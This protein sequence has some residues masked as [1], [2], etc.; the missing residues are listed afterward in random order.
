[1]RHLESYLGKDEKEWD[2]GFALEKDKLQKR[3]LVDL[4]RKYASKLLLN[5]I[6]EAKTFVL[7]DMKSYLDLHSDEK[8]IFQKTAQ[9]R[10]GERLKVTSFLRQIDEILYNEESITGTF[11]RLIDQLI[12]KS[13][14]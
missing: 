7:N 11:T 9:A 8:K 10:I 3:R 12:K 6:N 13:I 2:V 4:R 1:M 14:N 5:D